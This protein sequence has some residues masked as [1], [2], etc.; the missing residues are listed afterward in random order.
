MWLKVGALSG[1]HGLAILEKSRKRLS[2]SKAKFSD[3]P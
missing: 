3:T 1:E 2:Q